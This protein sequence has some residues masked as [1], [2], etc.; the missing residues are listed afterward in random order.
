MPFGYTPKTSFGKSM[1]RKTWGYDDAYQPSDEV[2]KEGAANPDVA[3]ALDEDLKRT[4]SSVAQ[5]KAGFTGD[6]AQ[7]DFKASVNLSAQMEG[8]DLPDDQIVTGLTAALRAFPRIDEEF[9]SLHL[10]RTGRTKQDVYKA[11]LTWA[12]VRSTTDGPKAYNVDKALRKL[13]AF[14]DFQE[15]AGLTVP[16]THH[17]HRCIIELTLLFR[18]R[19]SLTSTSIP[20]CSRRSLTHSRLTSIS[21]SRTAHRQRPLCGSSTA[22]PPAWSLVKISMVGPWCGGCGASWSIPCLT[23]LRLPTVWSS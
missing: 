18:P 10:H 13:Q 2:A 23:R 8:E 20:L 16:P 15:E 5:E 17:L 14:V 11:F 6:D 7:D 3:D 19:S 22:R 21:R 12:E 4:E 9:R 1:A